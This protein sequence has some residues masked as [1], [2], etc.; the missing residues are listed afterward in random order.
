MACFIWAGMF[1]SVID[2]LMMLWM[3]VRRTGINFLSRVVGTGSKLHD[4]EFPDIISF[5]KS[6]SVTSQ[7]W[8]RLGQAVFFT[9]RFDNWFDFSRSLRMLA[10]F[11]SKY[12]ANLLVCSVSSV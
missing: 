3:G 8:V 4:L 10:I 12:V 9:S 7:N 2:L 1:F 6:A 11:S 5:N